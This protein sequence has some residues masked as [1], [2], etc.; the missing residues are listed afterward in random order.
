MKPLQDPYDESTADSNRSELLDRAETSCYSIPH[1]VQG[2]ETVR[3]VVARERWE[4]ASTA[5][6][7]KSRTREGQSTGRV[8]SCASTS[9]YS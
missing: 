3:R 4:R 1:T 9:S 6:N 5:P 7:A 2:D 8:V